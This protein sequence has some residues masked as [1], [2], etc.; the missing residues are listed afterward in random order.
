[1]KKKTLLILLIV[2]TTM[3]IALSIYDI[4]NLVILINFTLNLNGPIGLVDY[5]VKSIITQVIR[6]CFYLIPVTIFIIVT[7]LLMRRENLTLTKSDLQKIKQEKKNKKIL[8][9]T[10]KIEKLKNKGDK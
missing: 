9:L 5:Y 3:L 10:A 8:Q 7:I 6:M 4:V 2:A 1:M